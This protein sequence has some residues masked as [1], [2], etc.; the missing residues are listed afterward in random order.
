MRKW[1]ALSLLLIAGAA[2][3]LLHNAGTIDLSA[4]LERAANNLEDLPAHLA[5]DEALAAP[6]VGIPGSGDATRAPTVSVA[7]VARENFVD[8]IM[9]TGSLVAREEIL[10]APE[11]EGLRV[12]SL[13]VEEGDTVEKGQLLASLEQ[14]TLLAKKA[15]YEA[16]L[17]RTEAAIAQAN[18]QV[19]EAQAVLEEAEAQLARAGPLKERQFMSEAVFDQRRASASTARARLVAAKDGVLLAR[20]EKAQI[21]AQLRE[22]N[23]S[24]SK[25]EIRAPAPGLITRRT[26]RI[27][28]LASA[29]KSPMFVMA[30]GGEI[31]LEARVTQEKLARMKAGQKAVVTVAGAKRVE[32]KVRLISPEID[33]A[34]RLG[35]VRIYLGTEPDL[36][37]GAFGRGT[38]IAATRSGLSLPLS[39]ILF[40]TGKAY[41]QKVADGKVATAPVTLGLTTGDAIE[42]TSGLAPG[43]VVVAKA[44]SF[45]RDGDPVRPVLQPTRLS[46]AR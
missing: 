9:V 40:D 43:D 34:T 25:T 1:I 30:R 32:G 16:N 11:V 31:E 7:A 29:T 44:G 10:I 18:S 5:K 39:A 19:K 41:V 20:A 12:I 26:V 14:E 17:E 24:L 36:R 42:I 37:V 28:D 4:T 38:V 35:S 22:V 6:S 46:E 8:E 13:D 33:P 27:G 21:E 15:Q 2:V 23:W 45:L 3:A